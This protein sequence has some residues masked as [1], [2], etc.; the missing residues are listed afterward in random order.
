MS[1]LFLMGV[2]FAAL[3]I[4]STGIRE[5]WRYKWIR[6]LQLLAKTEKN[7]NRFGVLRT[8]LMRLAREEELNVGSNTFR[9]LYYLFT[10]LMRN[11]Q[12]YQ[13]LAGGILHLPD[14]IPRSDGRN[15]P[16]FTKGEAELLLRFAEFLDALFRDYSRPYR[17]IAKYYDFIHRRNLNF[18]WPLWIKIVVLGRE[19]QQAKEMHDAQEKIEIIAQKEYQL[20]HA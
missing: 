7:R 17:W 11:P 9:E 20:A 10:N 15:T 5:L 1:A 3:F 4:L 18:K 16:F 19:Y 2:I 6:E 13:R 14:A 8:E 12:S